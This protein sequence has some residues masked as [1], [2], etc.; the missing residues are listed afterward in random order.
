MLEGQR[1]LLFTNSRQN[2]TGFEI[3]DMQKLNMHTPK[4]QGCI[5]CPVCRIPFS[6]REQALFYVLEQNG[7]R[8]AAEKLTYCISISLCPSLRT[9]FSNEFLFT[10]KYCTA[11]F[12]VT[13]SQVSLFPPFLALQQLLILFYR[14][15]RTPLAVLS[16][17]P[18]G[19]TGIT[20]RRLAIRLA[21]TALWFELVHALQ[22]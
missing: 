18:L 6:L 9:S 5:T 10:L 7:I 15:T 17:R 20:L 13:Y 11:D 22:M 19:L 4:Y 3:C 12:L 16:F 8:E 2:G 1:K 21:P 14:I